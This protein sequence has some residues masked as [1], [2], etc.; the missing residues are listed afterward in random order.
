MMRSDTMKITRNTKRSTTRKPTI[1]CSK[2][3]VVK[4]T[5][6]K[7]KS[8]CGKKS[9]KAASF[10]KIPYDLVSS[11]V[12]LRDWGDIGDAYINDEHK[13]LVDIADTLYNAGISPD[14][15]SKEYK[16]VYDKYGKKFFD[17]VIDDASAIDSQI[18]SSNVNDLVDEYN[19]KSEAFEHGVKASR[20]TV[21]ASSFRT[22][23]QKFL[24]DVD[25]EVSDA[26]YQYDD[27][28]WEVKGTMSP[29][30]D[31]SY[32]F[33]LNLWCD[34]EEAGTV[35]IEYNGDTFLTNTDAYVVSVSDSNEIQAEGNSF[36][37]VYDT[38]VGELIRLAED[39]VN[40][41]R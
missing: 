26:L 6:R 14:E 4:S 16:A 25:R 32:W 30:D 24:G 7:V 21:C 33:E 13:A 18:S 28:M 37:D 22:D 2:K 27:A 39:Y 23:F 11:L 29:S 38:C 10:G 12:I 19:E 40:F 17:M 8:A 36:A 15:M 5:N 9:V 3:R 20:R 1:A 35:N 31:G 41:V 34:G